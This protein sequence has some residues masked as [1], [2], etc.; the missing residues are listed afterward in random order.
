MS[1]IF[2]ESDI[3]DDWIEPDWS[4][5]NVGFDDDAKRRRIRELLNGARRDLGLPPLEAVGYPPVS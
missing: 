3:E 1:C 5:D 2:G 4:R